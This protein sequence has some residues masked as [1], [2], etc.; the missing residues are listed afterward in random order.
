MIHISFQI[1]IRIVPK[2]IESDAITH[3]K[4]M[5]E[6]DFTIGRR[7]IKEEDIIMM[8]FSMSLEGSVRDWDIYFTKRNCQEPRL[9]L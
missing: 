7:L 6:F 2:L 9:S 4:H 3:E 5:Q 1:T 8:L